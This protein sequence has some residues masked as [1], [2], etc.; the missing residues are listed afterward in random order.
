MSN[1]YFY[2]VGDFR[3]HTNDITVKVNNQNVF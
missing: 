3:F 2:G 1:N